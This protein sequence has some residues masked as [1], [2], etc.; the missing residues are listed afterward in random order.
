[1]TIATARI[2][3]V[4]LSTTARIWP[5]RMPSDF[6]RASSR[7]RCRT[8]AKIVS[9]RA[10]TAAAATPSAIASGSPPICRRS[11]TWAPC[12]GGSEYMPP[13]VSSGSFRRMR[14]T[15]RL[16]AVLDVASMATTDG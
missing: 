9:A 5:R 3:V 16:A 4:W 15:A 6:S 11:R 10:S 2:V 8:E 13:A 1:M 7:R 14:A 12:S